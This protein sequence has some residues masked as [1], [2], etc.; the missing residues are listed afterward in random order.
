MA[1]KPKMVRAVVRVVSEG[2][3]VHLYLACGHL[4]TMH[5][6][7]FHGKFPA[8]LECWACEQEEPKTK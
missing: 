2:V 5:K 4:I 1:A 8:E 3:L 7:D 6:D